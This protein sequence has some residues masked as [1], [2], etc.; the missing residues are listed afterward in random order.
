MLGKSPQLTHG[1]LSAPS[2]PSSSCNPRLVL[3]HHTLPSS[4]STASSPLSQAALCPTPAGGSR[5]I[6]PDQRRLDVSTAGIRRSPVITPDVTVGKGEEETSIDLFNYLLRQRIIFLA[7]YVNDKM[8]TQIVGS[9]LALEALD[10]EEDI[11]I[12]INSPGGQPYSVFG[13]LDAI[14]SIKPDV[15]TLGLGA[16]YSYA[17]LILAAG[18]KGKRFAMKNTRIM[19]TQ[20]MGGSQGDIYQIRKTVEELNAIYQLSARYYMAYTGMDQ[21]RVEMNT[22]R[23]FFM[24]PEDAV[25]EGIIDGVLRGKGDNTVPPSMVRRLKDSGLV[26]DL[27]PGFLQIE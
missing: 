26:D 13:V 19:M 14:Q 22:N 16:C 24:T 1:R 18:T 17:S 9:L 20:P 12:Y 4:S 5:L 8:A 25:L 15:Q 21:D 7:G 3:P 10:E 27:T 2:V 23:D 11:R 6:L